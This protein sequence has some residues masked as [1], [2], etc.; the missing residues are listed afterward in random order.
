MK[1]YNERVELIEVG[2][3]S[4]SSDDYDGNNFPQWKV[5]GLRPVSVFLSGKKN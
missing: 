2:G 3:S 4:S 1:M 5:S